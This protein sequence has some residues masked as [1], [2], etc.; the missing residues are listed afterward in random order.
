MST[1]GN[2]V[3]ESSIWNVDPNTIVAGRYYNSTARYV[4]AIKVYCR[5][6][7]STAYI[8]GAIY[9]DSDSDANTRLLSIP[10]ISIA[11]NQGWAWRTLELTTPY[12]VGVGYYWIALLSLN[13]Y[14]DYAY[15][16]GGT[17]T[18]KSNTY[19]SGAPNPWGAQGDEY[20]DYSFYAVCMDAPDSPVIGTCTRNSATQ[21][22]INWTNT[23]PTDSETPYSSVNVLRETNYSGSWELVFSTDDTDDE[24]YTDPTLSSS[25]RYRYKIQASNLAGNSYS[26]TS[27]SLYG[28][29]PVP[30]GLTASRL[31]STKNIITWTNGDT[32]NNPCLTIK[33]EYFI[34]GGSWT[35]VAT[36]PFAK[37]TSYTHTLPDAGEGYLYRISAIGNYSLVSSTSQT[38][39]ETII[40]PSAPTVGTPTRTSDTKTNVNW[41][42][43]S[44][45]AAPYATISIYRSSNGGAYSLLK[46]GISGS[47]ITYPDATTLEDSYYNYKIYAVN[48]AGTSP[49]SSASS[50]IYTRPTAPSNISTA[51]TNTYEITISWTNSSSIQPYIKLERDNGDG[52]ITLSSTIAYNDTDY[53]DSSL[54]PGHY[55]YRLS[56]IKGSLV[57]ALSTESNTVQIVSPSSESINMHIDEFAI[58]NRALSS[59]DAVDLYTS[60]YL[61]TGYREV[62]KSQEPLG[63]WP[64]N[65][66]S[67]NAKELT[68]GW[69]ATWGDGVT[70]AAVKSAL[71][72]NMA[73]RGNG[74]SGSIYC[75]SATAP[76]PETDMTISFWFKS[77]N[78]DALYSSLASKRSGSS[79]SY[80]GW[81]FQSLNEAGGAGRI[82]LRL[83]TNYGGVGGDGQNQSLLASASNVKD[84]NWHHV[85]ITIED[86]GGTEPSGAGKFYVDGVLEDTC[87]YYMG[88]GFGAASANLNVH[89][90]VDGTSI[91]DFAIWDRVLEISEVLA[92]YSHR[93]L[94]TRYDLD[95]NAVYRYEDV[96]GAWAIEDGLEWRAA[97]YDA[98]GLSFLASLISVRGGNG[99][100]LNAEKQITDISLDTGLTIQSSRSA[101]RTNI[102]SSGITIYEDVAGAS[103]ERI[104]LNHDVGL[105]ITAS[106]SG[107]PTI[108]EKIS[109]LHEDSGIEG[110]IWHNGTALELVYD[111][112]VLSIDTGRVDI[113]GDLYAASIKSAGDIVIYTGSGTGDVDVDGEVWA[114]NITENIITTWTPNLTGGGSMTVE[115][116][117][118]NRNR[119]HIVGKLYFFELDVTFE[120]GGS[121]DKT[122]RVPWPTTPGNT[123][124]GGGGCVILEGGSSTFEAGYWLGGSTSYFSVQKADGGNW[125]SGT[126]RIIVQ[127]FCN[128]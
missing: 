21:A 69:T 102:D 49:A 104:L 101:N 121:V 123:Y 66:T 12:Y 36:S 125:A 6:G 53:V 52:W 48:A 13:T 22:T 85:V 96:N 2:T 89:Q 107:D 54:S 117:S 70:H 71:P 115:S 62:V 33:L 19:T 83:D 97:P 20:C 32:S 110:Y 122:V 44:T 91:S 116:E 17:S 75:P 118:Y 57:S 127:G 100:S 108:T 74:D 78:T 4:T 58:W 60:R 37:T 111:T 45:S 99:V 84:G 34:S 67:G 80:L 26:A 24:D 88:D 35:Q 72:S 7:G 5:T 40:T 109:F 15:G 106:S 3:A 39:A 8:K 92:E 93:N 31:D 29:P 128:A 65:E 113:T 55:K 28:V 14:I 77:F 50:T 82:Y 23:N 124:Q 119:Y 42:N 41:T 11:A 27:S 112:G 120:I 25:S 59:V 9:S 46:S 16:S 87:T 98:K 81:N 114:D 51:K 64:L 47:S 76:N 30:T 61:E 38:S 90:P 43:N 86:L 79:G 103:V 94:S 10:E 73:P 126:G 18:E 105:Q 63:Y 95:E 56:T 1:F 68:S